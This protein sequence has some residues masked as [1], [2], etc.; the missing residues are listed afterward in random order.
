MKV[1]VNDVELDLEPGT[2]A[3]DAVFAAGYDVPY[4]C[5]QEYMSPIG[6]CRLCLG[7][8]GAPR[9]DR[10]T[11]DWIRD[12]SGEPK[13]FYFPN[14]MAT[15]TTAIMEGMV[16]DTLSQEVKRAQAGM[17][18]FTLINHPLDCPVCDKGGACELQD[19]AYE[20]GEGVSRFQFDKRHQ[21]KHHALSELI[22]LDRERCIHCK[23]CV[24]Y[25]EE[26]P[27][28]EV[29]DF[30]ERGGH[31]YIGTVDEGLPSPF[32]GN[33]TDIC[34]VG[35]LLDATSRFR[36]RNWEYDH[37]RTTSPDDASGAAIT[38]DARTGRIERIKAA[39]NTQ[40]NL[41]WIDDSTRFGHEYVDAPDRLKTPL[42]RRDGRLVPA[43]WEEAAA[44]I[45]ERLGA[46]A[47][48]PVGVVLRADATLEEGVA[49]RA[50]AAH[51][52]GHAEH[53][54]RPAASLISPNPATFTDVATSD[55]L[56]VVGDPTEEVPTLDLRIKDALKGVAPPKLLPHGVPIADLRLKERMPRKREILTVA[57]PYR[58]SLA[59]HAGETLIY[60][61]GQEA[62]LFEGVLAGDGEALGLEPERLRA[63][64]ER[65]EA[66][67]NPVI[68]LGAFVLASA[69]ATAAAQ[70]LAAAVGAKV[71][72]LGPMANSYGLEAT[73]V[74]SPAGYAELLRGSRALFVSQL[75]P[76]KSAPLRAHLAELELLVVHESFPT[77]TTELAHVV[78]PAKTGYE[79]EGTFVNLEG[80]YLGVHP[81]PVDGG[82]SEDF[83]GVVRALG[84][85]FGTRL[86]GRSVRSAR[87]VLNKALGFDLAALDPEGHLAPSEAPAGGAA[88]EDAEGATPEAEG[89]APAGPRL[90]LTP[91]LI[92]LGR[93]SRNPK[94]HAAYGDPPLRLHPRAAAARSLTDGE[95]VVVRAG[96]FSRDAVVRC[97]ADL[98]EDLMLLG[99]LFDQPVGLVTDV[100]VERA[101]EPLP[102][103]D[104]EPVGA[105]PAGATE[106]IT[107]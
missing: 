84:E 33:I 3:I 88:A 1:R 80:R 61:A 94:L 83:T 25:F 66:A 35:A 43:S 101:P 17:M 34:P 96:G 98:P 40:V 37:T 89:A 51:L 6:A 30:M 107:A 77:E 103:V 85:A 100:S 13:I 62:A 64:K 57:A 86:D 21:E 31:T 18:E 65:L 58:V 10:D 104:A 105:E 39:R 63:L 14:L 81:A 93:L 15:C 2:S 69:R 48:A 106:E 26:V 28:D 53:F 56:F 11:N 75:N 74:T 16:I 47:G 87:R 8:I 44:F 22:T 46:L 4:F 19:R 29:L 7:K 27:G 24:R 102:L 68:V 42:V 90:L 41:D 32:T 92:K 82:L 5:S 73:G 60:P 23:R 67:Q 91:S 36:G 52:G 99:A 71:M 79:K 55:A 72:K 49:A 95:R 20:Y 54:P 78:L 59:R 45:R 70:R 50:L 9:K 97:D 38:V 76:A 12:E